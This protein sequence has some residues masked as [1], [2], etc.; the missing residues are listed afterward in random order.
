MHFKTALEI[1]NATQWEGDMRINFMTMH[2]AGNALLREIERLNSRI[3]DLEQ[4]DNW[5]I[6]D[7]TKI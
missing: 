4:F 3:E 2:R 1:V 7:D 5:K 6:R